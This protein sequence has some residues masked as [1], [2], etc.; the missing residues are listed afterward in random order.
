MQKNAHFFKDYI[1]FKPTLGR[2]L[3]GLYAC[4]KNERI[5]ARR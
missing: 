2:D 1:L 3:R 5:A 4:T